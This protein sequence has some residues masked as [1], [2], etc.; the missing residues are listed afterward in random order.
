MKGHRM[1][2]LAMMV[3]AKRD[4]EVIA[5][6]AL[7]SL[8]TSENNLTTP[9]NYQHYWNRQHQQVQKKSNEIK[10]LLPERFTKNGRR[11]A[12]PF[13]LKLMQV[14]SDEEYCHIISWMPNGRSFVILRPK[15]FVSDILP[16]H[17]K[18]AQYASF[19]RKLARWGFA[20]CEDGTGEFYHPQFR[21]GRIDL[22]EKMTCL[23]PSSNN[24]SLHAK[25]QVGVVSSR[26]VGSG[27]DSVTEADGSTTTKTYSNEDEQEKVKV[28]EK[29]VVNTQVSLAMHKRSRGV[30]ADEINNKDRL[31]QMELEAQRLRQCIHAAALSRKALAEM[32]R[33]SLAS[34]YSKNSERI[35]SLPSAGFVNVTSNIHN[36]LF[37]WRKV[38]FAPIP[39]ARDMIPGDQNID[40][41][42]TILPR[43]VPNMK[44]A[45]S[46]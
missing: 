44:G 7:A 38:M 46:A 27:S 26:E 9:L 30:N 14:L 35:N 43:R 12:I 19:T 40:I 23:G 33:Q 31:L 42:S 36:A 1:E 41:Y 3:G 8:L 29:A 45:K 32:Q 20:R 39:E 6:S 21:K 25:N 34:L 28:Q 4:P 22:A 15:A 2:R 11:R 5:A 18:S 13:P 17:F 37:P 10:L 24:K 16:K